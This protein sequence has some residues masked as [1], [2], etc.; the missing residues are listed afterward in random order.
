MTVAQILM[1]LVTSVWV[2]LLFIYLFKKEI[3][4]RKYNKVLKTKEQVLKED[5]KRF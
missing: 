2:L 1:I 3:N 5:K 4:D